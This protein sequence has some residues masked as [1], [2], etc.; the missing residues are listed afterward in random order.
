[1]EGSF[2]VARRELITVGED[3]ALEMTEEMLQ[4]LGIED[5]VEVELREKEIVL[6][7]PLGLEEAIERTEKKYDR[8]LRRLAE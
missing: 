2:R 6:R 5:L 7:R 8:A 4:H 3:K 1:M